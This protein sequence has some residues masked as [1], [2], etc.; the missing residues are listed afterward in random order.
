VVAEGVCG[1]VQIAPPVLPDLAIKLT[2]TI[3]EAV[4]YSGVGRSVIE[5]AIQ[6]GRLK[7]SKVGPR[8]AWVKKL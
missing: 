1:G 2:L 4:D 6:E 3:A 8:G 7:A 5:A